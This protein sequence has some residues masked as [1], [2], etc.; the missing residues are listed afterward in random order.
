M[1]STSMASAVAAAVV[2]LLLQ[3]EPDLTPEQVKFCLTA[4]A[5]KHWRGYTAQKAGG[6]YLDQRQL[7]L[8][9]LEQC[10]VRVSALR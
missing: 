8:G 3:D 7:D 9:E 4:T 10:D 1:S 2:A 5:T 6:S